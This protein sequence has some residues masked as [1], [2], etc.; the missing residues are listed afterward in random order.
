MSL[1]LCAILQ[2]QLPLKLLTA[3]E[4]IQM[5]F[6][7]FYLVPLLCCKAT[8]QHKTFKPREQRTCF[9]HPRKETHPARYQQRL[10][11]PEGDHPFLPPS[12]RG[13]QFLSATVCSRCTVTLFSVQCLEE[14]IKAAIPDGFPLTPPAP[15]SQQRGKS[16][17]STSQSSRPPG[18]VRHRLQPFGRGAAGGRGGRREAPRG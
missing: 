6:C 11:F 10:S 8:S 14:T 12:H 5:P 9:P 13:I 17:G 4:H 3:C 2:K 16:P 18:G 15:L 1:E 7:V